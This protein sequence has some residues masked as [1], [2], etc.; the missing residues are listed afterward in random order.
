MNVVLY[1]YR[2]YGISTGK[3]TLR[4]ILEDGNT[5]YEFVQN[6]L[7][8]SPKQIVVYGESIGTAV[9]CHIAELHECAGVILQSPIASLPA[10]AKFVFVLLRAYPDFIF[11]EPHLNNLELVGKIHCPILLI[12]GLKDVIVSSNNSKLLYAAANEPRTLVYLPG[13]GHNDM[14]VQ[15]SEL[16]NGSIS[17]FA[18]SL[19]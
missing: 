19:K 1:D 15:D 8:Y 5:M 3:P 7:K 2:G 17:Q 13:C 4:G 9:T 14:G 12:H 16:F 18:S 6:N 11:P 10:A